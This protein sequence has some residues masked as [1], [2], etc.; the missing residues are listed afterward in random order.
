MH[1]LPRQQIHNPDGR[2]LYLQIVAVL[3]QASVNEPQPV[4]VVVDARTIHRNY[5]VWTG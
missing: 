1:S 5:P 2:W 4:A 3:Q